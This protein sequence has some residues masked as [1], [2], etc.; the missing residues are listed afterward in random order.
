MVP[1]QNK[2]PNEYLMQLPCYPSFGDPDV[3]ISAVQRALIRWLST[4][5]LAS[6][7]GATSSYDSRDTPD[8]LPAAAGET[9]LRVLPGAGGGG[10]RKVQCR[11]IKFPAELRMLPM[12]TSRL[13]GP[14]SALLPPPAGCSSP[15]LQHLGKNQNSS[16]WEP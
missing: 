3:Q 1:H 12:Q 9:T 14:T 10:I 5:G 7:T 6:S 15:P 2:M 4:L 11:R 16:T 8:A 13:C